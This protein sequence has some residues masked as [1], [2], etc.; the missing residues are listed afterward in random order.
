MSAAAKARRVVFH[1]PLPVLAD[2]AS[3]SGIR[4][5]LMVE[6]FRSL[7]YEVDMVCGYAADRMRAMAGVDER[8]R[9]G[10]RY[11]FMYA[12]SSTE[13][14]LL[15][16][17][18]HL[19]LHPRADFAF[20]RRLKQVGVPIGLFY[21]D[22][23]WRFPH[24]G[25]ALPA[26]KRHGAIAMYR[27]DLLQ[28]QKLL[29]VLY[30][31]SLEMAAYVPYVAPSRMKLLPPGCVLQ[32]VKEPI[33]ARVHEG[34]H[35]LYVGG[36]GPHYEMQE[37]VRAMHHLPEVRLTIC[38]RETEWL[39]VRSSYPLPPTGN[40][41][42]EHRTGASLQALYDEADICMLF[43]KPDDYRQFAV[44]FKLFEY[45]GQYK[46]VIASAGTLA[47]G[48]VEREALGWVVPYSVPALTSLLRQLAQHPEV[49]QARQLS[50]RA[51]AERHTWQARAQQVV[52][53][54][55]GVR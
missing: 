50:L 45:L 12:E 14:T 13:P 34:L 28:Y 41:R 44:P 36:L 35:L 17:P 22:I 43:V 39:A 51:I 30:L 25:Q 54:L 11:E 26:W 49:L 24:Y 6:A 10:E 20:M 19:P 4:P 16:E 31:Q 53:D 52:A 42:I 7:G 1:H 48:F 15:T 8:M 2:A 18:H 27:Y 38:T 29:N 33:G 32:L 37:L 3:A 21:R 47:A 23:Y 40:V 5:R 46:P 55:M 9:R